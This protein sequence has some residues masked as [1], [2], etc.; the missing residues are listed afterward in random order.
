LPSIYSSK[1]NQNLLKAD[2]K[3]ETFYKYWTRKAA[4]VKA[5]GIGINDNL[6]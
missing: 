6:P 2:S 5:I 4:I 3:V 1:E